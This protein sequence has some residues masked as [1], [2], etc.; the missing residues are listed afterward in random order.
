MPGTRWLKC[1]P[2]PGKVG[3]GSCS[4]TAKIAEGQGT[5]RF[6]NASGFVNFSGP[7]IAY[8]LTADP[9]GPWSGV[10]HGE[11][12]GRICNVAQ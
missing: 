3:F 7:W 4:E 2:S 11:I 10:W 8:P 12:N 5:G 6:R 9:N 1:L